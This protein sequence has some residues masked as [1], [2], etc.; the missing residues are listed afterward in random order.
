MKFFLLLATYMLTVIG[1]SGCASVGDPEGWSGPVVTDDT[2]YVGTLEGDL[3]AI[4]V[5]TG[6]TEWIFEL[7]GESNQTGVYGTPFIVEGIIYFGGYDGQLYAVSRSGDTIW[8]EIV[9]NGEP[10]V[11]SAIWSD[12]LILIGS[13][14]GYLYAFEADGGMERWRFST[15]NKV[16]SGVAVEDGIAYFGSLDHNVY[17]VNV[18]DGSELWRLHV[19]GAVAATPLVQ[20]GRVYVGSFGSVFY[21]IDAT[22]G[23]VIW[24]FSGSKSWFWGKPVF[25]ND[26]IYV[27]SLDG[28]LY[29][30]GST[31][32]DLKWTLETDGPIIGSP[33]IIG[34]RIAVPS[35]DGRIHLVKLQDGRGRHECNI[36][37]PIRA[38]L[39][40]HDGI[41]YVS[42]TD[43]SIRALSMKKNGNPDEE[44]VH[45]TNESEA[46]PR[47]WVRSC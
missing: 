39:G 43:H 15:G 2:I 34:D 46:V 41:I 42:A 13:S 12:G 16:W 38:S 25:H 4:Q 5:S 27:P 8:E 19:G 9:G 21:S 11:G 36:G 45:F 23:M 33:V 40:S 28:N 7:R 29:A 44:W 14:D 32:G 37:S 24:E 31:N 3:R 6:D 22:T 35:M 47:D 30:V 1:L 10:L 18:V 20:N 17:A 26:T